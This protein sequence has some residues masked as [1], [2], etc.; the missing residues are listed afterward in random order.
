[1]KNKLFLYLFLF[2]LLFIIYQY[3]N[4]KNIFENQE[5]RITS[6][7][8][9]TER[10]EDSIAMMD[11]QNMDLNYF[12]LQGNE[13]AMTYLETMNLDP[14]QV[15]RQVSDYILDQNV[16]ERGNP[17]IPYEGMNGSMRIN[18][19]RFLNHKWIIADFSDGT[20]WGEV[21]IAY[22]FNEAQDLELNTLDA[23]LYPN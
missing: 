18:K 6:L 20:Y 1:M 12:T 8:T 3:M 4:E 13:N 21:L 22:S 2:A 10:L 15:E 16:A 5:A 9:K 17:L 14:R 19:V 23:L 11:T 7:V